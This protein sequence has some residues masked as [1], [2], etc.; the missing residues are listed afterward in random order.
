MIPNREHTELN[1][2]PSAKVAIVYRLPS[3]RV[4]E[5]FK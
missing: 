5:L 4:R 2:V 3:N 1:W